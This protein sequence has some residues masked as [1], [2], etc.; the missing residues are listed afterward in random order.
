MENGSNTPDFILAKYLA[1]CLEA[2]N[3]ASRHRERWYGKQLKIN[4]DPLEEPSQR[5]LE[6]AARVWCDKEMESV[7]MDAEAATEIARILDAVIE[8]QFPPEHVPM[9]LTDLVTEP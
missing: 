2:F 4:T 3:S 1:D 5:A 8:H 7:V 6:I 9:T